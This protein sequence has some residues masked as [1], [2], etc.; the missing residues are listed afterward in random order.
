MK[1][2][3]PNNLFVELPDVYFIYDS[4]HGMPVQNTKEGVNK[5]I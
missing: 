1:I 3:F 5:N 2:L 4:I